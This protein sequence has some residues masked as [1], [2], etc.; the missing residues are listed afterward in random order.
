M[1][2][3]KKHNNVF[4]LSIA[5]IV[6]CFIRPQINFVTNESGLGVFYRRKPIFCICFFLM[7]V[8]IVL[9]A[10]QWT[11]AANNPTIFLLL[12]CRL[13]SSGLGFGLGGGVFFSI[14]DIHLYR[15]SCRGRGGGGFNR[16][17][18]IVSIY[19][20]IFSPIMEALLQKDMKTRNFMG[21]CVN[22]Y[23]QA[24]IFLNVF[25]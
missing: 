16:R 19:L 22:E 25:S 21:L 9:I 3:L 6:V 1:I 11:P 10:F 14:E 20:A 8:S 15:F 23:F 18:S 17:Q 7:L 4:T 2:K 13:S 24:P 5:E 12:F